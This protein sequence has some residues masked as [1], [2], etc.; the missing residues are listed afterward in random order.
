M[1]SLQVIQHCY[2]NGDPIEAGL[3]K[4]SLI[5]C[6][7]PYNI[8]VKYA[9]D[10]TKDRL[11]PLQYQTWCKLVMVTLDS[12]LR[13]GGTLWWLCPPAHADWVGSLLTKMIGPRLYMIVKTE[14]FAQY[15]QKTLTEDYRLLYCHQKPGGELTFNPDS[16]RVQSERQ[17]MG[18]KRADPR[19]RVPGQIWTVR[20]LQGTSV[21]RVDWHPC[22]LAPEL[23]S[24][25]VLGWSNPG[26]VVMDA[27]AGSGN[28]GEV[29][30]ATGRDFIGVD[31]SPTYCQRIR[32]RLCLKPSSSTTVTVARS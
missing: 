14:T 13:P 32:E 5:F 8:G 18:D 24:R 3:P 4:A 22:Q 30:R 23:L 12:H 29:C 17:K 9:D 31:K 28:M 11:D 21:D 6:D 10:H 15:Q 20:R 1:S 16:I 19:G 7:P 26:E 2:E 25:I 27:F